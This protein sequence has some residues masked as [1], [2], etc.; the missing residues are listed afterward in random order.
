MSFGSR[1]KRRDFTPA[2]ICEEYV[3]VT[4]LLFHDGI[5]PVQILKARYVASDRRDVLTDKGCAL[6]QLFLASAGDYDVRTFSDEPLG[7]AQ[8][9]PAAA[10]RDDCDLTVK[11]FHGL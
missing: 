3:D 10:A 8:A 7:R 2:G 5:E 4:V 6:F 9:N 1:S 11:L